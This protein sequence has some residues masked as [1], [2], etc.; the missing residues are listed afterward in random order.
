ME[1]IRKAAVIGAGTMGAAIAAQF[2]NAG[3][4]VLLLDI[5]KPGAPS[6]NALA[7]GAIAKMLKTDPAPFMSTRAAKLVTPGNIED[8]LPQLASCD[9]VVEAIIERLD[10]KQDLYRKIDAVR[11]PGMAVSSNTSTI[12]LAKLTEGLPESFKRDF[13]ITHFFNPPRYM[14]LLE[15]VT[16]PETDPA[17]AAKVEA[18]S[19]IAL[20]KS[21]VKAKDSPGFIANRLGVFWLQTGVIEAM[22]AGLTV[23]EAD[24]IMG[25]PFGIPKTGVFG[26]IDLVGLDLMPHIN[27]SLAGA[28]PTGDAFH[29]TNRDLPLIEKMIAEGYTGRKGKGGF[30]RK[31]AKGREAID[32]VSGDY[33]PVRKPPAPD[34]RD[35]RKLLSQSPYAWRVMGQTLAYAA[36]LIPEAAEDIHAI[37]EAMRLGYNWKFGPFELIDKIGADWLAEKLAADHLPVP[38]LLAAAK[39]KSFYRLEGANRDYLGTDGAYHKLT[40]PGGV[41][42][43][44]DIKR[45]AKPVLK[46]ASAA[47]WDIG[48]G[49][50]CFELTSKSNS[51][52]QQNL[53]LLAKTI[54]L[55]PQNH[56]ALVIYN[57]GSH[58]SVGAN[59]GLA[60]FAAN[61]AAW[62]EIEKLVASGQQ[63][64]KKLKYAPFPSIAAPFGMALGGGCEI[65]LHSSAIQAHAEA[66]IGLVECGVGLVPAWGGCSEMLL[67]WA[68]NKSM[69]R[70]PMPAASKVFEMVSTATV[71]KSAANAKELLFLREPDGITMNRYRLL[72]DAK[73][74]ALSLA[75]SYAPPEAPTY[76]LPGEDGRVGFAMAVKDFRK[77]GLATPYDEVVAGELA[78]VLSGGA[79]DIIDRPTEQDILTLERA[80]FTRLIKQDGTLA[81]IETMLTT[82]KPLRN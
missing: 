45:A 73:A 62:S 6:R 61:I 60:L 74:K 78:T 75:E 12:P 57:E 27:A 15:L 48:D 30:Y 28:L 44:E 43:L 64:F 34:G 18:F 35:M 51:W 65:L 77:K 16:G 76:Q 42:M 3:V 50:L 72:A 7:E 67:R 49:V 53:E 21:V 24:A 80:A 26:L 10:L 58:F 19:D 31:G 29:A 81:R 70:G 68:A 11:R 4:P 56:K 36:S 8:D 46:N 69:P 66:Y 41:L 55:V 82:G 22:D 47:V 39:G 14:R 1:T 32:L 54:E 5:V 17:L 59:L 23:E 52:D 13:L 2:A 33:R 37:D 63:I 38:A 9:W 40:R 20:G 25:R 79:A 71:S